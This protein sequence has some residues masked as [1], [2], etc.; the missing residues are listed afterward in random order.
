MSQRPNQAWL[1]EGSGH[2]A[3]QFNSPGCEITAFSANSEKENWARKLGAHNFLNSHNPVALRF[4]KYSLDLVLVTVNAYLY[5]NAYLNMPMP[6]R[7]L[8]IVGQTSP[9]EVD[10]LARIPKLAPD[11]WS[12]AGSPVP[13]WMMLEFCNRHKIRSHVKEFPFLG[14]TRQWII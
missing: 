12:P 9:C 5:W 8:H 6:R 14:L 3:L 10:I 1:L 4:T 13:I 11:R 2:M 7:K